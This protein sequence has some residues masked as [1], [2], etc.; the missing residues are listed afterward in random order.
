[1]GKKGWQRA[2][3]TGLVLVLLCVGVYGCK[4]VLPSRSVPEG[5]PDLK[6]ANLTS[7]R[8]E[9]IPLPPGMILNRQESFLYETRTTKAGLLVYEGKGEM[10]EL[11]NF[12]KQEM[13]KN[14]WRLVSN[15]ELQNVMLSFIKEGWSSIIY[16]VPQGGEAKR[17]EIRVGPIEI[18]ILPPSK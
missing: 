12:F 17:L 18:K 4:N 15:F 3:G 10:G 1:M 11:S 13:P 5:G 7:Y 14:D 9:D 8:F 16:I 2:W 6:Q